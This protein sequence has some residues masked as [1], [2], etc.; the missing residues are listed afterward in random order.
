MMIEVA[1][2]QSEVGICIVFYKIRLV[3]KPLFKIAFDFIIK[4]IVFLWQ[5][6]YYIIHTKFC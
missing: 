1:S 2:Q 6:V 3:N 4:K 5:I